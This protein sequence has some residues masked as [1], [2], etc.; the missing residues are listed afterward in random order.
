VERFDLNV[1]RLPDYMATLYEY[2]KSRR[3]AQRRAALQSRLQG[4]SVLVTGASSGIGRAMA[5]A[6][7]EFAGHLVLVARRE[8]E[9]MAVKALC[10]QRGATVTVVVSDLSQPDG[11]D[12]ALEHCREIRPRPQVLINSAGRSVRRTLQEALA[13][14]H[15]VEK[16]SQL[17]YV[18]PA[19]LILGVLPDML[20]AG[21]GRIVNISSMIAQMAVPYFSSYGA[22]KAALAHFTEPLAAELED[23]NILFCN[24]FLPFVTTGMAEK[25]PAFSGIDHNLKYIISTEV[26]VDR[27]LEALAT[28]AGNIDFGGQTFARW[29]TAYPQAYRAYMNLFVQYFG[30]T[31]DEAYM[32]EK[33]W[34]GQLFQNG[35]F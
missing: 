25:N 20:E 28:N 22:S 1:H 13:K 8:P 23:R 11:V 24:A 5:I 34:L 19:K 30:N 10:E 33:R 35:A 16:L 2:F 18:A 15:D 17:N 7:A 9:L 4:K 26:A 32:D 21:F 27:I 31:A 14:P 12:R 6:L 3:G 29:M